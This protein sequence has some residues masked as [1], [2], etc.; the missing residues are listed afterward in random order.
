M[1]VYYG[2][3]FDR[4]SNN[5]LYHYGVL[6]MRWGH[7][8]AQLAYAGHQLLAKNA[9]SAAKS[10]VYRNNKTAVSMYKAEQN[11]QNKLANQAKQRAD[12][13]K[14]EIDAYKQTPEHQAKVAKAKKAAK[15]GAAVAG[16]ALAAYGAYKVSQFVKN[17]N[18]VQPFTPDQLRSMGIKTFEPDRIQIDRFEP[19]RIKVNRARH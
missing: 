1:N 6:G 8:K 9:A 15:I 18:K 12:A 5:E 3:N 11:R 16:T 13:K 4:Y 2:Y 7:R 17:K 14:A 19:E 10:R